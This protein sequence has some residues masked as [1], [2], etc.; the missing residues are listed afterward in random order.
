MAAV[1]VIH[2]AVVAGPRKRAR[3]LS[4]EVLCVERVDRRAVG[5]RPDTRALGLALNTDQ[6][7]KH[8]A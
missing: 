5:Q 1:V 3:R 8:A 2:A 4:E 7:N 6:R